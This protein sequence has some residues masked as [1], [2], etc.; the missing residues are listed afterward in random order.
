M[1]DTKKLDLTFT[2]VAVGNDGAAAISAVIG[3]LAERNV[4]HTIVY[5]WIGDE[6]GDFNSPKAVTS[7]CWPQGD[8][9]EI[10]A[11]TAGGSII[12]IL[13][14]GEE[15]SQLDDGAEGPNDLVIMKEMRLIGDYY[16]A[17]GMARHAYRAKNPRGKWK[18]IDKSCFV[19]RANRNSVV[20][21]TGINGFNPQECYAVGYAG[22]IWRFDGSRWNQEHSPTNVLLTKL[23]C[24]PQ[25]GMVWI[26]GLVGTVIVGRH[27]QW[28]IL[29]QTTTSSDFWGVEVFGGSVYLSSDDGVFVVEKDEIV[30]LHIDKSKPTTSFLSANGGELWSVGDKDIF[31]SV[32]GRQWNRVPVP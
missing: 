16:F 9:A 19:P 31:Q 2:G 8:G 11:L 17:V 27:G 26:V 13:E 23:A 20:G 30:R 24:D 29:E 3:E 14:E 22:E 18:A 21:F 1:N 12:T 15:T 10:Y 7:M 25:S 28:R 32:D 6:W 5:V 4:D